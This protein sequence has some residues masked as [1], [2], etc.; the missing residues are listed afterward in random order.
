MPQK[1]LRIELPRHKLAAYERDLDRFRFWLQGLEGN[2][3]RK[4]EQYAHWRAM[5]EHICTSAEEEG[6]TALLHCR[7]N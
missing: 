2:D 5:R 4:T 7:S 1:Y 3:L 6:R